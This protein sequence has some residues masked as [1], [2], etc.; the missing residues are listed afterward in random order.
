MTNIKRKIMG[1]PREYE[2]NTSHNLQISLR[3]RCHFVS[4][5]RIAPIVV[6]ELRANRYHDDAMARNRGREPLTETAQVPVLP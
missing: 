5:F 4:N 6:R 1:L 2:E 3:R